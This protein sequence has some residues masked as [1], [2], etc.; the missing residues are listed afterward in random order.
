CLAGKTSNRKSNAVPAK[1]FRA[2]EIP[3]SP[4]G[5][6]SIWRDISESSSANWKTEKVRQESLAKKL[7]RARVVVVLTGPLILSKLSRR[8]TLRRKAMV[9]RQRID[10]L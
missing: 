4:C 1:G 3:E 8:S 9:T 2:Q 5:R 7:F 10:R 6:A